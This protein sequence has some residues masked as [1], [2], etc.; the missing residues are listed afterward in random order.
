M[1]FGPHSPA[2]RDPARLAALAAYGIVDT[3]P[4]KSYDDLAA[5]AAYVCNAPLALISF[6]DG[7]R[8]WFKAHAG[9][10]ADGT[11]ADLGFCP[12]VVES[13]ASLEVKDSLEDERFAGRC[14]PFGEPKLRFYAGEP[15]VTPQGQVLGSICVLDT[16]PRPQGLSEKQ[17][18]ALAALSRQVVAQLELRISHQESAQNA[19]IAARAEALLASEERTQLLLRISAAVRSLADV[20]A[21]AATVTRLIAEHFRVERTG[22]AE[23][24]ADEEHLQTLGEW[25]APGMPSLLARMRLT[26]YGTDLGEQLRNGQPYIL[27][28]AA[29]DP[30]IA[31]Q[32][33]AYSAINLRGAL[34]MPL[35]KDGRLVALLWLNSSASRRWTPQEADLA[36]VAVNI[37]WE[38]VERGR[39]EAA[40]R[41]SERKYRTLFDSIDEGFCV[42]ELLFD[43]E[44]HVTDFRYLEVNP[45][46]Q[47]Q[48]G[49]REVEGRTA[50]ELIPGLEANWFNIYEEVARTGAP[51][52]FIQCS[53]ALGRWFDVYA[54]PLKSAGTPQI[55]VLFN[56]ITASR[57]AQ[58]EVA[59]LGMEGRERLAEMETLLEVLPIGIG[60]A[61]DRECANIRINPAFAKLLRVGVETNA[62]KS[63]PEQDV[64]SHF[65]CVDDEGR[66]IP[67]ANLPMQIAARLG[68][69]VDAIELNIAHNDGKVTRLLEYAAPLFDEHGSPRGSVGAFVDITERRQV[70][71]ALQSSE[72]RFRAL[73]DNMTQLA[74]MAECDGAIFWYNKRWFD[75]T[76][77]SLEE[78][79]GWGWQKVHHPDHISRVTEKW[80]IHLREGSAWEDTFPLR[81]KHG[82]FRWFLSRATPIRDE[83]GKVTLWF[84]TNTDVTEQ[85]EA[86]DAL[87]RAR[88]QAEAASRAKDDF[89][90]AL[91][92]ELRTPLTP[93]LMMAEDLCG[94]PSLPPA[95]QEGLSMMRR[96]ISLEARLIDDLLDLTRISHGKLRLREGPCEAHSLIHLAA[97]IVRD[98]ALEKELLLGFQLEALRTC[99]IGDPA[100]LQQVFWNILKNAVKFTPSGGR[101][102]VHSRD[103]SDGLVIEISDTGIGLR[104]SELESIFKP[105]DQGE[106]ETH[107][108]FGGLGLGL[109]ISRSMVLMHGGEITASSEGV[110]R[111]ATFRIALPGAEIMP[112][113]SQ[114]VPKAPIAEATRRPRRLLLVE[115]HQPTLRVLERLLTREGHTVFNASCVAEAMAQAENS[116]FDLVISDI[117]LPDGTGI[118]LM[119]RLRA[120]YGLRGIALSGYGM[121]E[122]I[123][124]S[125]EAGFVAHLTKPVDFAQLRRALAEIGEQR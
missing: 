93:V 85:R 20:S 96:N 113:I 11:S 44:S 45:A 15:L 122:D 80:G 76:G 115:D 73:A 60:I 100:R 28:D 68:Q 48:T 83:S 40:L 65:K 49:L 63:G 118:D 120:L 57:M 74:W 13:G 119:R 72:E 41:E 22:F 30:R 114:P 47:M 7:K 99:L 64:T 43:A 69:A 31:L 26:D 105:F 98:E 75:Y 81:S 109:A 32:R 39:A 50:R 62:S 38:A 86:A 5:L 59:K 16:M 25:L 91:S 4:E 104:S 2:I 79:Q 88:D 29:T 12:W 52:R 35:R 103:E 14:A 97:E 106:R 87:A 77:T 18:Q 17:R 67:A 37:L 117:G 42:L 116:A 124:R 8:Q 53:G 125:R 101:I 108:R 78:M 70:E 54:F 6:V 61:L 90:A 34:V 95:M 51:S 82:K 92:H 27:E 36:G 1:A 24:E 111:G 84:G 56:D 46:F 9:V 21:M 58:E 33:E 107:H 112:E 23:A 110:G 102:L 10:E 123:L 66:E 71:A 19:T 121:D 89:L 3:P 55:A 94:D